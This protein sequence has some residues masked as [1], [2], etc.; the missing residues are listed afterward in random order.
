MYLYICFLGWGILHAQNGGSS[1]C[2]GYTS[3]TKIPVLSPPHNINWLLPK[4]AKEWFMASV[5]NNITV[6]ALL[7][8]VLNTQL[9]TP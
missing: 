9:L 4:W 7:S 3:L 5:V 2:G 8:Q 1:L 6:C